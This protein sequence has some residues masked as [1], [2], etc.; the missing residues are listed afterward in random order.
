MFLSVNNKPKLKL[1]ENSEIINKQVN[2]HKEHK[3]YNKFN[4]FANNT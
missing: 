3:S 4:Y 2:N 1:I